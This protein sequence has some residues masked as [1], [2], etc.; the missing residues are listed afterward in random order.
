[1][2][3]S[4]SRSMSSRS[5]A[6]ISRWVTAPVRSRMRSARVD[7]PWSIWAMIEKLRMWEAGRHGFGTGSEV[8]KR[9]RRAAEPISWRS[10][11]RGRVEFPRCRPLF[12]RPPTPPRPRR[13][14]AA[15]WSNATASSWRWTASTS[16]SPPASASACSA[17]TV[18]ARR[19][20]SS[21]S[22]ACC[23]PTAGRSKCLGE[24]WQGDGQ[25]LRARLGVQLQ[26]TR[27]P[28][29]SASPSSPSSSGA[30]TARASNRRQRWRS[31][32]SQRNGAPSSGS[33]RAVR[34]NACR[35]PA[36]W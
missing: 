23:S 7:L 21:S 9:R 28:R 32:A 19:P 26:E 34:S 36:R 4:R 24:R 1:M 6:C 12:P 3:R 15:V 17:R 18:P 10:C 14:S 16:R 13:C 11:G 5:C 30:S 31:S 22:R 2:P 20:Q 35:S 27:F 33:L 25:A 29:S 8:G